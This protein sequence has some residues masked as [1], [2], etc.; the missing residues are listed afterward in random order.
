MFG[1]ACR[2]LR[3]FPPQTPPW[4]SFWPRLQPPAAALGHLNFRGDIDSL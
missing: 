3:A 1:E 4:D 2:E